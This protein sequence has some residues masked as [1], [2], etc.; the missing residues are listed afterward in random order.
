LLL[1]A[2]HGQKDRGLR[3]MPPLNPLT[4]SNATKGHNHMGYAG[5]QDPRLMGVAKAADTTV[6]FGDAL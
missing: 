4:M 3:L 1:H 5:G 6:N 2:E